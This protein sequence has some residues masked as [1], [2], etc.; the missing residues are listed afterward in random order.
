M[1]RL[2]LFSLLSLVLVSGCVSQQSG[3]EEELQPVSERLEDDVV[4]TVYPV[5]GVVCYKYDI[6]G[7]GGV[8]CLPLDETD[9]KT[10][11]GDELVCKPPSE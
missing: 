3:G 9:L 8:S 5:D 6:Y 2:L 10:G 11:S 1:R 4:R 7:D